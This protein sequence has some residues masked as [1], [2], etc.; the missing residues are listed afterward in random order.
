MF[1]TLRRYPA[2]RF[3]LI[4]DSGEQDPEVYGDIARRF[5]AQV[6]GILIRNVDASRADDLRYRTAFA[7]IAREQWRLFTDP[8]RIPMDFFPV[9]QASQ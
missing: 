7:G 4:G 2:R 1:R 8:A 6:S 3:I 9:P 5:P